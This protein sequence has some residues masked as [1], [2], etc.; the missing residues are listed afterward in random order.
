MHA[1]GEGEPAFR[2]HAGRLDALIG[3]AAAAAPD[4]AFLLTADHGMNPKKR[5]WDLAKTCRTA[6]AP[7]R[8][9]LSPERDYY[10]RHHRNFTGCAWVW[11]EAPSDRDRVFSVIAGLQGVE[12]VLEREEAASRFRVDRARIGD[13]VVL[14]DKDTMFGELEEEWEELPP[15]YRAHGSL[16]E[17]DVPLI[18]H[19]LRHPMPAESF[20]RRNFDLTRFLFRV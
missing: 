9:V 15:S 6:G 20:F 3:S 19:N 17:M 12:S 18:V 10:V 16:H 4:A 7:V 11:L 8:F 14:G 2:S 1:W 5:C 13:L